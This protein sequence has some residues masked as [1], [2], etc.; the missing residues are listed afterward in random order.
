MSPKVNTRTKNP[1]SLPPPLDLIQIRRPPAPS[2]SKPNTTLS[3][4]Q[5]KKPTQ[6]PPRIYQ[7]TTPNLN[8][9]GGATSASTPRVFVRSCFWGSQLGILSLTALALRPARSRPRSLGAAGYARNGRISVFG[10]SLP[11]PSWRGWAS[12]CDCWEA[13]RFAAAFLI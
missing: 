8:P 12:R 4:P 3:P 2:P 10:S 11:R 1:R 5:T 9:H 6:S 7:E 13:R